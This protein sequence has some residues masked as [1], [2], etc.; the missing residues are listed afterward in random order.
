MPQDK[1]I[2]LLTQ[3][4]AD[5]QAAFNKQQAL[6]NAN[7]QVFVHPKNAFMNA[8]FDSVAEK[9]QVKGRGKLISMYRDKSK[10]QSMQKN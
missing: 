1:R 7:S 3:R 9:M 2:A 4:E 5:L 6:A 10:P 8:F